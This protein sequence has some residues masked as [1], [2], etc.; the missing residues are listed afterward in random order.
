[1]FVCCFK[2]YNLKKKA[3]SSFDAQRFNVFEKMHVIAANIRGNV[4]YVATPWYTSVLVVG[5]SKAVGTKKDYC[6]YL[7]RIYFSTT[8][9]LFMGIRGSGYYTHTN[10]I[11][12]REAVERHLSVAA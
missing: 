3:F 1:M 2:N 4:L 8:K 10:L 6:L 7:H 5:H 12:T 11:H 9:G